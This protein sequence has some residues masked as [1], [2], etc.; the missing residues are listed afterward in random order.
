MMENDIEY[1]N[2]KYGCLEPLDVDLL[3]SLPISV[4]YFCTEREY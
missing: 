3:K 1:P 2:V 4:P